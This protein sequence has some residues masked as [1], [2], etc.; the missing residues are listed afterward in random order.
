MAESYKNIIFYLQHG[1]TQ[2]SELVNITDFY[3]THIAPDIQDQDS[4][5]F[6]L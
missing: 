5:L 4:K 2:T 1:I 6:Y 3:N